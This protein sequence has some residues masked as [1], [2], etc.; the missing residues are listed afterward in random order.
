M[1]SSLAPSPTRPPRGRLVALDWMRGLV[2]MLM[3][4]DH[5]SGEF[6][7]GRLFTD[8]VFVYQAGTA[9]PTA[10][11]LTRWVTHLCAPTFVFLAGASL[12][13]QVGRRTASGESAWA[14]DRHLLI[15]G[16]VI[17]GFEIWVS[18]FWMPR[19]RILLQSSMRSARAISS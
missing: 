13:L 3:A 6:N 17:A 19:G 12:A 11:F 7:A 10:Q 5:S 16:L 9:L 2:M 1:V 18:R 4:L 15:R 8:G 14:I